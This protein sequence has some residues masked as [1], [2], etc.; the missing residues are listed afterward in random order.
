MGLG[1][2][3]QHQTIQGINTG[4]VFG[5]E[6]LSVLCADLLAQERIAVHNIVQKA[7]GSDIGGRLAGC[8]IV[9]LAFVTFNSLHLDLESGGYIYYE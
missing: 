9:K 1:Q 8:G 7:L 5:V 4:Y 2:F 3:R 6:C